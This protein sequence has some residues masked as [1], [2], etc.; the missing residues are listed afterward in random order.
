M[1]EYHDII[2]EKREDRVG[3]IRLNRPKALNA[4]RRQLLDELWDAL[5]AFD[6]DPDIGAIVITG[7]DRAFSAGADITEMADADPVSMLNSTMSDSWHRISKIR[8]PIIAAVSGYCFGGGLEL[9]LVCDMIVASETAQFG[10]PEINIGI[11]PGGGGTQRLTRTVGKY[12][13]MEMILN[14][15][16]LGATEAQ[17]QG[18]VNHVVPLELYLTEALKLAGEIASRAPIALQLGKEAI[19][20]AFETTLAEGLA[21]EQRLFNYLFATEDQKEGMRAFIEKR[22]A[23]WKGR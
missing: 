6:E 8:K 14:D 21:A 9:A 17:Q 13:A 16:R 7:N 3:V 22:K 19:N 23:Q 18:L 15:R 20:R 10:Q 5:Q 12:L 2:V 11:I 4:L 1:S